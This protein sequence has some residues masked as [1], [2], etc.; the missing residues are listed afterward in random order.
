M[1][2]RPLLLKVLMIVV[3][4]VA[5][6][7]LVPIIKSST[8]LWLLLVVFA[9]TGVVW[10]GARQLY[11][12]AI[13]GYVVTGMPER[14]VFREENL[15]LFRNNVIAWIALFPVIASGAV[16]MLFEALQAQGLIR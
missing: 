7:L 10:H 8:L 16:I 12:A 2:M 14:K 1:Q 5:I 15:S 11:T 13:H 9:G 4:L 3:G 6:R